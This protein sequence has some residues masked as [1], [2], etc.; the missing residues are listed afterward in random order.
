MSHNS[1]TLCPDCN[2]FVSNMRK[3]KRR[4][5]CVEQHQRAEISKR[6]SKK[7]LKGIQKAGL[8]RW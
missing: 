1:K 6:K 3:H 2:V 5:R 7:M 4:Q 8:T